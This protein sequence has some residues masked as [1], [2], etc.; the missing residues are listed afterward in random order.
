[1]HCEMTDP[2]DASGRVSTQRT[3]AEYLARF[4]EYVAQ[5]DP[6]AA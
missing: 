1:M 6:V 5:I 3:V 4:P 2:S